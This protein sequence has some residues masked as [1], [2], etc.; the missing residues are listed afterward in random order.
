M[1]DKLANL[2]PFAGVWV[3]I[4]GATSPH[5]TTDGMVDGTDEQDTLISDL[6]SYIQSA[7]EYGVLVFLTLWN[8]AK[9]GEQHERHV[10]HQSYSPLCRMNIHIPL[11]PSAHLHV[12]A[13]LH[14]KTL[15]VLN[16]Q[17]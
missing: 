17:P 2:F 8:G 11:Q 5:F 1:A 3:H 16:T 12:R 15:S 14:V 13:R 9:K 6:R 4:E 10:L 7:A